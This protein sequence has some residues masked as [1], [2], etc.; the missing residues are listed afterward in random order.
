VV[1]RLTEHVAV[2]VDQRVVAAP[3]VDAD[4]GEV[5]RLAETVTASSNK[6]RTFQ[7]RPSGA[8]TSTFANRCTMSSDKRSPS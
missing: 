4:A 8:R 6:P 7:C 2:L 1:E 5:A 3:G